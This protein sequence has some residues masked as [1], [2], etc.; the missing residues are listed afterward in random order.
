MGTRCLSCYVLAKGYY[1]CCYVACIIKKLVHSLIDLLVPETQIDGF[2][3]S[4]IMK[5]K[6]CWVVKN[7]HFCFLDFIVNGYIPEEFEVTTKLGC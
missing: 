4:H 7:K 6:K 1:I 2:K 3:D 5:K